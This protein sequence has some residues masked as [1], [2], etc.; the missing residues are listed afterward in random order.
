VPADDCL[1]RGLLTPASR[2]LQQAGI[3]AVFAAI[4]AT[5]SDLT[6]L[7][8]SRAGSSAVARITLPVTYV[9]ALAIL[10]YA[11][12]YWQVACGLL[13]AGERL[14]RWVFLLGAATAGIGAVI[15]GM[16]GLSLRY[17]ALH[18]GDVSPAR[19]IVSLLPL[20]LLG[21]GSG[22]LANVLYA[23]A[24]LRGPTAYPRW[25][26]AANMIVLPVAVA[27][28][29]TLCRPE[30]RPLVMPAAPN[31]AHVIFFCLTTA[32]LWRRG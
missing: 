2:A 12:G 14:A 21:I 1:R 25:M 18:G 11:V 4:L 27:A 26:A 9:G 3:V 32:A 13:A 28:L 7:W 29:S 10:F 19:M 20:W 22:V 15:H 16:T 24:I 23:R 31:I 17:E 8:L 6:L 5:L 30:V